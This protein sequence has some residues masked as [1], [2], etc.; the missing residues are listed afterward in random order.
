MTPGQVSRPGQDSQGRS[1]QKRW[2]E[3]TAGGNDVGVGVWMFGL[4]FC[5]LMCLSCL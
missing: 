3:G 1:S 5:E 4:W 2:G